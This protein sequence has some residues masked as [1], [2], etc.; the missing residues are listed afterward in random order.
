MHSPAILTCQVI[1]NLCLDRLEEFLSGRG[2][3]SMQMKVWQANR[4]TL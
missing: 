3:K 2:I 1:A 4:A